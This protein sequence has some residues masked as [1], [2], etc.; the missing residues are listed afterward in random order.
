MRFCPFCRIPPTLALAVVGM[1]RLLP[2]V[3]F[4]PTLRALAA[5]MPPL[6]RIAP[7]V[8]DVASSVDGTSMDALAP[9]PPMVSRVVA[10]AKAVNDVE[11]VAMLPATETPVFPMVKTLV[12]VATPVVALMAALVRK[13]SSALVPDVSSGTACIEI[14]SPTTAPVVQ[15][16]G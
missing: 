10:P 11:L 14:N 13:R 9:V 1:F 5:E 6:V 4:A 7:V 3:M 8:L 16:V 2:S 12:P 15:V